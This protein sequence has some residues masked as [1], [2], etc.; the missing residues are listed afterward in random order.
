MFWQV[1]LYAIHSNL[2]LNFQSS[3]TFCIIFLI[4]IFA[5]FL[6][7]IPK[8]TIPNL[9]TPL[10]TY[11]TTALIVSSVVRLKSFRARKLHVLQ[12]DLS[13]LLSLNSKAFE[14]VSA[15]E[16]VGCLR[17]CV[18]GEVITDVL[19][20]AIL[21]RSL[22]GVKNGGGGWGGYGGFAVVALREAG[23]KVR[24]GL[25]GGMVQPVIE[26]EEEEEE[27]EEAEG[28]GELDVNFKRGL[29]R[30]KGVKERLAEALGNC[31]GARRKNVFTV[32]FED[33]EFERGFI[34]W[35]NR[36]FRRSALYSHGFFLIMSLLQPWLDVVA[37]C[38]SSLEYPSPTLCL[39][40]PHGKPLLIF[41][42]TFFPTLSAMI[43]IIVQFTKLS[44]RVLHQLTIA[45]YLLIA[46]ASIHIMVDIIVR[47]RED[48]T[49]T[50]FLAYTFNFLF[51]MSA[52]SRFLYKYLLPFSFLFIAYYMAVAAGF[53]LS[54]FNFLQ[55]LVYMFVVVLLGLGNSRKS[56]LEERKLY[57]L[58]MLLGMVL[59]GRRGERRESEHVEGKKEGREVM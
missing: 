29:E 18:K 35:N 24:A 2:D 1:M 3:I 59:A 9:L 52:G 55:Y 43:L 10:A 33:D 14:R 13:L 27:T 20:P 44:S 6:I 54:L 51:S 23:G 42:L 53:Q 48:D 32:K 39:N 30:K 34:G 46:C 11:T 36:G 21:Q 47:N 8:A 50:V 12:T 15:H 7:A 31:K 38:A 49:L 37:F 40:T 58:E 41:R 28:G 25:G 26:E 57:A 17:A 56:E 22:K 19:R 5:N 16:I 4:S 45:Y